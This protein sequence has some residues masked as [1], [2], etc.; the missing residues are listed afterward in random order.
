[1]PV[2][3]GCLAI[4]R[5]RWPT[6]LG[7]FNSHPAI[8]GRCYRT[9]SISE[10]CR[11]SDLH[12]EPLRCATELYHWEFDLGLLQPS[13]RS[14]RP[15]PFPVAQ[16]QSPFQLRL[17]HWRHANVPTASASVV[18]AQTRLQFAQGLMTSSS[19]PRMFHER[20]NHHRH[21]HDVHSQTSTFRSTTTHPVILRSQESVGIGL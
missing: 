21:G 15:S 14:P 7:V 17:S 12:R 11:I 2:C 9:D 3:R 4:L 16:A 10:I 19:V 13:T 6:T 20:S 18:I 5:K 1:M 8:S